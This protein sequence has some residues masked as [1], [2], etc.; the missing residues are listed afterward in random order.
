[1]ACPS[2]RHPQRWSAPA[3]SRLTVISYPLEPN[4]RVLIVPDHP[5]SPHLTSA[6]CSPLAPSCFHAVI[7]RAPNFVIL[8]PAGL[9][10]DRLRQPPSPFPPP[11][12]SG[13]TV[14]L[15]GIQPTDP[16]SPRLLPCASSLTALPIRPAF[17]PIPWVVSGPSYR[18]RSKRGE[19]S[20]PR[21]PSRQLS[22]YI[23]SPTHPKASP[24]LLSTDLERCPTRRRRHLH[25]QVTW[26]RRPRCSALSRHT[27]GCRPWHPRYV[28]VDAPLY[29]SKPC[30][31]LPPARLV[32]LSSVSTHHH[33]LA[34]SATVKR[35]SQV[36]PMLRA[37]CDHVLRGVQ[38]VLTV[39]AFV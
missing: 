22:P 28:L 21:C 7:I 27:C 4:A 35:F 12:F 24:P 39:R 23:T 26:S 32:M 16:A 14:S 6:A 31:A 20:I 13:S 34:T 18:G 38:C 19:P 1:M 9:K 2:E 5:A 29:L 8:P 3:P 33:T 36:P 37:C 25:P 30:G 17:S 11:R 10:R 15:P